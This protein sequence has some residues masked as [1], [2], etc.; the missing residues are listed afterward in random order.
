MGVTEAHRLRRFLVT[1]ANW[2]QRG[3]PLGTSHC[4]NILEPWVRRLESTHCTRSGTAGPRH[5]GIPGEHTLGGQQT[6][7]P[8]TN[9]G[10]DGVV[11]RRELRSNSGAT[12]CLGRRGMNR[13]GLT[14]AMLVCWGTT[15]LDGAQNQE[16]SNSVESIEADPTQQD[17]QK[18]ASSKEKDPSTK[19]FQEVVE[20]MEKLDGL[21][22]FY[23][24]I[25]E[26]KTFIEIKPEQFE[27][28]YLYSQKTEQATGERGLYG[29]NM[30]IDYYVVQWQRLGNRLQLL[31]RNLRFR[32]AE[33]SPVVR[34]VRNSFSD[35][36]IGSGELLGE[37]N[38]EGSGVLVDLQ[39]VLFSQGFS[40]VS[41]QI[42]EAY[43]TSYQFEKSDSSIVLLKSFP[44]NSEIGI[45]TQFRAAE[46]KNP[47]ITLPTTK[48]LNLHLR[49][50]IASLPDE[51][52]MPRLGDDR[53]GHFYDTHM[54][55][56]DDR[57]ETPYVRYVRR[58][59][60]EKRDPDAE[61]SEPK[62]PIVFWLENSI[63]HEYRD[64]IRNGVLMWNPAFERVGFKNA[65]VVQQQPDDADWDPADIRYNTIRWFISYDR[66]FAIGPSHSNPYTGQQI[67]ADI[68]LS[69]SMA[70]LGARRTYEQSVHP[71][72]ELEQLKAG[73]GTRT[74]LGLQPEHCN[75]GLVVVD[76]A[77]F[78]LDVLLTRPGWNAAEEERFVRQFIQ[79]ITAHEVGH[80]L[81]LRHNFRGS[82]VKPLEQL[83][84]GADPQS[85]MSAS[86]MD[87]LPPSIALPG[88]HQG[89]FF[90]EVVGE[91]DHWAVEYAYRPI[92]NAKTPEDEIPELKR[93]ASRISNPVLA[94]ATDED[95][96]FGARVLDPRNNVNDL[97]S[98]PLAWFEKQFDLSREIL[99]NMESRLLQQGDGYAILRRTVGHIWPLYFSASHVAMKYIGGI[100]HNRDHA[101]DSAN[102]VPYQPVP[103]QEQRN[104]LRFLRDRIWSSSAIEIAPDLLSKLQFE[105][106]PSFENQQSK[107]NRLDYPFYSTVLSVQS[108]ALDELYSP[109]KLSRLQDMELLQADPS[110]RFLMADAFIG[111]RQAIWSELETRSNIE[112]SRRN[113]Q[114]RHLEQLIKL[115]LKAPK[116]TPRDAIALARSDLIQLQAGIDRTL[117]S[118]QL[119]HSTRVYLEDAQARIHQVLEARLDQQFPIGESSEN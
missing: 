9:L 48:S 47:S 65:I 19:S 70:R 79:W 36:V 112:I 17:E 37:P 12:L 14:F 41:E 71:A 102:R 105:R 13:L 43:G 8:V 84:N 26:N 66:S 27:R 72:Q 4:R 55:F 6:E 39:E 49:V 2:V 20:D 32:A 118:R 42:K 119:N 83:T 11:S 5:H 22:T 56:T 68:S 18:E 77:R 111:V 101:G 107:A 114:V 10:G 35:S 91:Y 109:A 116:N 1:T 3:C 45:L 115:M 50:S 29:T 96:G 21:F 31:R 63:P 61:V 52:Y 81:A 87:Y 86:V 28:D 58:W 54:D 108:A 59:K 53:I 110:S 82:T 99:S 67:A 16:E 62:N 74:A 51:P 60:L 92:P 97:S 78:G 69:E 113:L 30:A 100:Y 95:S 106:F 98:E 40:E 93:I 34:A 104:A 57:S 23:R 33:N 25:A 80:T 24:D 7:H 85:A 44:K 117:R 94:Y 88:E 90:Q 75:I 38:P 46:Q 103:A 89:D 15:S 76:A 73:L 64:W